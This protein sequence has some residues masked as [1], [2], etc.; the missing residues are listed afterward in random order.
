MTL[1]R[2]VRQQEVD[3]EGAGDPL[4]VGLGELAQIGRGPVRAGATGRVRRAQGDCL[5]ADPFHPIERAAALLL[6]DDLAEQGTEQPDLA[7]QRIASATAADTAQTIKHPAGGLELR[8]PLAGL[9]DL[10]AEKTRLTKERLKVEKELDGL[11][12]KLANPQFVAR[13][14]PEV[15]EESRSRQA[16]LLVRKERIEMTLV[17]LG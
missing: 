6:H 1:L 3:G 5:Q 16:E 17:D 7:G 10:A 13:A 14:K 15:V 2:Q 4:R 11:Q 12:G 9:F 8:I